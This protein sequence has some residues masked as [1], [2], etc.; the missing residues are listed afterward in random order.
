M[1]DKLRL[2]VLKLQRNVCTHEC[3]QERRKRTYSSVTPLR[4]SLND[5]R[6]Q[7][8]NVNALALFSTV[9]APIVADIRNMSD[10]EQLSPS[11]S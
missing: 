3:F 9:T 2:T 1:F 4:R 10:A 5:W 11:P 8:E 6:V 7:G